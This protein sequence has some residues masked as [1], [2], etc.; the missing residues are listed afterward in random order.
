MYFVFF[1]YFGSSKTHANMQ[2]FP[3]T[4]HVMRNM[5]TLARVSDDPRGHTNVVIPPITSPVV[6]QMTTLACVWGSSKR[7]T[8]VHF[9]LITAH[10]LRDFDMFPD[11]HVF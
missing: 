11:P 4:L 5:R 9:L 7:H 6:G 10:V 8:N 1:V 3:I 2:V